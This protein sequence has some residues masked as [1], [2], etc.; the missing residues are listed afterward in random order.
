MFKIQLNISL[1]KRCMLYIAVLPLCKPN[2]NFHPYSRP[3]ID[4]ANR[5]VSKKYLMKL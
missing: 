1:P 2:S 5:Q 4:L 3:N